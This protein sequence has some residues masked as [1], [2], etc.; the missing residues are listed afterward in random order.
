M[1][2]RSTQRQ[3]N[4]SNAEVH[5]MDL[6]GLLSTAPRHSHQRIDDEEI[7]AEE[8]EN[9]ERVEAAMATCRQRRYCT[10]GVFVFYLI[11][12]YLYWRNKGKDEK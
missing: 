2:H 12:I 7:D 3:E 10:Y 8:M 11:L 1:L 4:E 5:L 6:E 9:R